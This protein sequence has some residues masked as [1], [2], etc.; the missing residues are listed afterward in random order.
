MRRSLCLWHN[1]ARARRRDR[2]SSRAPRVNLLLKSLFAASFL[3]CA[4]VLSA[5]SS[6]PNTLL[7]QPRQIVARDGALSFASP[8]TAQ[9][10]GVD[11]SRLRA[12]LART[13]R[14]MKDR[15]GLRHTDDGRTMVRVHVER[16]SA[17]EPAAREDESYQLR[18]GDTGVDIR[19]ANEYGALR[20]LATLEQ[21]LA[22]RASGYVLPFVEIDDAPRFAWRGLLVDCS[23]HFEPIDEIKRTIDAMAAVKLNVFHWHLVDDQGFRIESRRY[24]FLTAKGSDGLFYTQEQAREV[25]D[26][27]AARGVR[28]LPEFE[29]PG[30]SVAW[31]Y[32]YPELS[33]GAAPTG[34]RREFG[35]SETAI[36]PTRESTY[37]FLEEFLSEMAK[38]FPDA[39]VHIGGDETPAPEWNTNARIL[40]FKHEHNLKDNAALQAYFNGRVQKIL[41]RL[42]KRMIGWD[43]VLTPELPKDVAVQSWRGQ[44]SLFAGAR[45]GHEGVLSA[46]F[47]LDG[48]KTAADYYLADPAPSSAAI[49]AD[50]RAKILGGEICMWGEHV[51]PQT[52]DSRIWPRAAAIAERLWSPESTCDVEDMYRR[53][54]AVSLQLDA[55]GLEHL[56]AR[57]RLL[58]QLVGGEDID[59]MRVVAD[60]LEPVGFNDRYA[61]QKTDQLTP[62]TNLVD[63]LRPDPSS[64]HIFAAM[65][66]RFVADPTHRSDDAAWLTSRLAQ[67]QPALP[68]AR[69]QV[70]SSPR[71][72]DVSPRIDQLQALAAAAQQ[73]VEW[74]AKG[75]RA[76]KGWKETQF[77]LVKQAAKPVAMTRI[78]MLPEIGNLVRAVEE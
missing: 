60:Y 72:Q 12:A 33:S 77:A 74:L 27:A 53:L 15:A 26:Y 6:T 58:R 37:R 8:I 1:N 43:E 36:D 2:S 40:A 32:A 41:A 68:Q 45:Q 17:A 64:R 78:N 42:H 11:T 56:R 54:D 62:M 28:V 3:F 44:E 65:V 19:A 4:L 75:Q 38:I 76:P 5:Q 49:N 57:D 9:F 70:Q 46:P 51:S 47:Y 66:A 13:A 30:H 24:P 23:R 39:Y 59:A 61:A 52:L 67:L 18:V 14:R 35:I 55:L 29:M 25:V 50:E 31:L 20:A 34:V 69:A 63:A 21:L 16:E 71:L 48:M 73:A 22:A 10:T 7:P